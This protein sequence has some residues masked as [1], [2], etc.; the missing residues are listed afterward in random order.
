MLVGPGDR[1]KGWCGL[2]MGKQE[3]G[4]QKFAA[5]CCFQAVYC[6]TVLEAVT[7]RLGSWAAPAKLT[8]IFHS[9]VL[10]SNAS[11][12]WKSNPRE[13]TNQTDLGGL[14]YAFFPLEAPKHEYTVYI[15][16]WPY[17][18]RR[19][20]VNG[21]CWILPLP[22]WRPHPQPRGR[23]LAISQEKQFQ[24]KTVNNLFQ[25]SISWRGPTTLSP[26]FSLLNQSLTHNSCS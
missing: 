8:G 2:M 13:L 26:T 7:L 5:Q 15:E 23:A 17:S 21:L 10:Q 20:K 1:E 11:V 16:I 9:F 12:I 3:V 4:P 22:Q 18:M 14:A 25:C 24:K 19:V 6:Q